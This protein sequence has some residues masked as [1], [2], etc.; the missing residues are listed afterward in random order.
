MNKLAIDGGTPVRTRPFPS[1]PVWDERE[2]QALLAVLRSGQW[3]SLALS[4]SQCE[5]FEQEFARSHH[6]G[7]AR[8]VTTGSAALEV[9]LRAI[10]VDYGDEVI[11]PPYTFIATASACLMVGAIPVFA[12]IHPETYNIDPARIEER[13]T[14][15]TRAIIPVHIG[16]CP[17]DMDAILEIAGRH[18]LS[19]IEDA[20]QS[21]GASWRGRR[22]GSLGDLGCFSFQASKNINAGEGG[23]I[24][25]N[26]EKLAEMCWSIRSYGRVPEGEWYQHERLGDNYRMTEWQAAILRVQLTR[27]EGMAGQREENALYLAEG[28]AQIGGIRPQARDARI[29]QHGYHLFISRYQADAFGGLSRD[30]FL[31]ALRAEGIPCAR[32]YI[33]VYRTRAIQD[34]TTRLQRFVT[35][36]AASYELPD[37]PV[38]ERACEEEGVWFFQNML[39]GTREDMDDIVQAVA[40][41]K[42]R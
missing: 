19:V 9:S 41:I 3:G 8:C 42:S 7:Y 31:A 28:L 10:G 36:R 15:R 5:Q 30:D 32:G 39:L 11:V 4:G 20:C 2:E 6:A 17:A 21:H 12:D 24:L 1:W 40:K 34:A 18:H 29:T 26:D 37:C 23:V 13:I 25:T 27:L 16:G 35:G 38:A 33:P 22:V 14:S